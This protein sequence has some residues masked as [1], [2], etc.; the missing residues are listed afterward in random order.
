MPSEDLRSKKL[1]WIRDGSVWLVGI[2]TSALVL[3]AT[4]F[5]DKFN[6]QPRLAPLLYLGWLGLLLSV[7]FGIF[8]AFSTW[9]DLRPTPP[10]GPPPLLGVWV[11]RCYTIMMWSFLIGFLF[12]VSALLLNVSVAPTSKQ[13]IEI[14]V[15]A[16]V[17]IHVDTPKPVV[18]TPARKP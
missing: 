16:D 1:E 8:T 17:A 6:R 12:L 9:K 5:F 3:S 11:T 10:C 13:T 15:P 4:F 14:S 18:A 2:A 7:L